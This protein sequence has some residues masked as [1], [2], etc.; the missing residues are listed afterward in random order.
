M[1][2]LSMNEHWRRRLAAL[3][4]GLLASVASTGCWGAKQTF[5][6][7]AQ[8]NLTTHD[9]LTCRAYEVWNNEPV[10]DVVLSLPGTGTGTSAF[11][12]ALADAVLTARPAAYLTFDKP[13]VRATFGDQRSV[14]IDDAPFARHTEGTLLECAEAALRLSREQF[15]PAVRWHF[16]GHSEGAMIEL[17]LLDAL[18]TNRPADAANVR[19]LVFSGLP[20]EPLADNLRRQLADKPRL[21][22]AVE[23]CAWP[24]MRDQLGVSCGYLADARTRPSGFTLFERL[25]SVSYA[26]K[27]RVFQGDDDINTLPSFSHQLEAWNSVHRQLDLTVRYYAAGHSGTP[28]VRQEVADLLLSLV[29]AAAP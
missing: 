7:M 19:S 1:W 18:L 6:H 3:L 10:T 21:A 20:L 23:A 12:P 22:Q 11:V 25:A 8:T 9:D 2:K 5:A 15:G 26:G 24:V 4:L 16:L 13:G 17:Y 14:M 28:E 29:P 27:I